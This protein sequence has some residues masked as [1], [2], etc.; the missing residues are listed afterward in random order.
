VFSVLSLCS[1][2]LLSVFSLLSR[3]F[4]PH[5]PPGPALGSLRPHSVA[6][7]CRTCRRWC[8]VPTAHG[9]WNA[10]AQQCQ[11]TR[12]TG[13]LE[14]PF[15]AVGCT[16]MRRAASHCGIF[17]CNFGSI[18]QRDLHPQPQD[19]VEV[20][21]VSVVS[22]GRG[23]P[24]QRASFRQP[25]NLCLL[26]VIAWASR[27]SW[28]RW[29]SMRRST[30][31]PLSGSFASRPPSRSTSTPSPPGWFFGRHVATTFFIVAIAPAASAHSLFLAA[32]I[33]PGA[34]PKEPPSLL[35]SFY[36]AHYKTQRANGAAAVR[37]R[38][39]PPGVLRGTG[40]RRGHGLRSRD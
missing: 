26:R 6:H 16:P 22:V 13:Q 32:P 27:S 36:P 9:G 12:S 10:S 40:R 33:D 4:S 18:L 34:A 14:E 20:R 3:I 24:R 2:S 38:F 30:Q 21:F 37:I 1:L 8:C 15:S 5:A 28:R 39:S 35:P 29:P 7:Q 31:A 23:W 17:R 11:S 19:F 25:L